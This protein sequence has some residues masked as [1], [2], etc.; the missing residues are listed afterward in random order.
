MII[1][2]VSNNINTYVSRMIHREL[3]IFVLQA[4]VC[5]E[6]ISVRMIVMYTLTT[7]LVS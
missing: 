5:L 4:V 1:A 2:L 3:C 7:V 6:I